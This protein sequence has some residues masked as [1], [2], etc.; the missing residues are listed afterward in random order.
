MKNL[1]KRYPSWSV[2]VVQKAYPNVT[3]VVDA[4]EKIFVTVQKQDRKESTKKSLSNCAL[5]R[6][7]CREL[8]IDAAMIGMTSSYLIIGN[9]AVRYRT[10]A[11]VQREIVSFDR[12]GDFDLG[13]YQLSAVPKSGRLGPNKYANGGGKTKHG[14]TAKRIMHKTARVRKAV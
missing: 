13:T 2:R 14:R 5:A 6:A 7:C 4:T 11:V 3:Q 10:P 12:H 9:K 1:S 8:E